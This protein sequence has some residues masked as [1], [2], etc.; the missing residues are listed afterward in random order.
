MC[1]IAESFFAS[2][3][4]CFFCFLKFRAERKAPCETVCVFKLVPSQLGHQFL[5]KLRAQ[6][7]FSQTWS[8]HL[9]PLQGLQGGSPKPIN[10]VCSEVSGPT[11]HQ[12]TP[13]SSLE[14]S[15]F[16]G[17]LLHRTNW[18]GFQNT[19]TKQWHHSLCPNTLAIK[20]QP[21]TQ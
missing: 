20:Q 3:S 9:E 21:E 11:V 18:P 7:R 17:L 10:K 19:G 6:L 12:S 14:P 13:R 4:G 1:W 8:K 15:D 5:L 16:M 2:K